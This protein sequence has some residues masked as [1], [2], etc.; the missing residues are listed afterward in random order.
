LQNFREEEM[1]NLILKMVQEEVISSE[2]AAQ[3]LKIKKGVDP[4]WRGLSAGQIDEKKLIKFYENEGY[5]IFYDDNSS[6]VREDFFSRFFTPD[7][8]MKYLCIPISFKKESKDIILGFINP[9]LIPQIKEAI[10]KIFPE[11]NTTFV[12]IP[13]SI[14]KKIV[15]KSYLFDID[16]FAAVL[17]QKEQKGEIYSNKDVSIA[18]SK[19][20]IHEICDQVFILDLSTN[21]SVVLKNDNSSGIS[22]FPL[23]S[24]PT[25]KDG[26][27]RGYLEIIPNELLSTM[28]YTERILL[29]TNAG[30]QKNDRVVILAADS[31]KMTFFLLKNPKGTKEQLE[32]LIN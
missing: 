10:L 17:I 4:I 14:L 29:F 1:R 30:I 22:R 25:F 11:F 15:A 16:K 7:V 8:I 19:K 24:L 20:K 13:Y 18:T 28:S 21:G 2:N 3:L 6:F 5:S 26:F 12:H 9:V 32:F 27:N 23:H 31:S